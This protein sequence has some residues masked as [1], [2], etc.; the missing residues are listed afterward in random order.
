M[1]KICDENKTRLSA[2][3]QLIQKYAEF[4]NITKT[5]ELAKLTQYSER[6]IWKAKTELECS[7][8]EC[9]MN[10]S[11][12]N[13]SAETLHSSA[14]GGNRV[15]SEPR[16]PARIENPSGL[17]NTTNKQNTESEQVDSWH[18]FNGSTDYV[19]GVVCGW[20]Q[21]VDL[22]KSF[23][24]DSLA[25]ANEDAEIVKAAILQTKQKIDDGKIIMNCQRYTT[26]TIQRMKGDK[27]QAQAAA[28]KTKSN[29]SA[30]LRTDPSFR[31]QDYLPKP[32]DPNDPNDMRGELPDDNETWI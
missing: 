19:L 17:N 24:K 21:D 1:P 12:V 20:V 4:E 3:A 23:I 13:S 18:P 28:E 32:Y 30:M 29:N 31:L 10:S 9:T 27:A 5:S 8:I 7:E 6:A 22:A 16:A 25:F 15:Q 14:Q 26:G 2:L 11:A